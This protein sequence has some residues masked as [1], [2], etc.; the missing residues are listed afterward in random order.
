MNQK[1]IEV[2][3]N[4]K[5]YHLDD[6][7]QTGTSLK[8]LAGIPLGD[9]L[10]LQQRGEDEVIANEAK[11]ALKKRRPPAQPAARRLRFGGG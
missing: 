4:R 1:P 2:F 6:P 10:F 7:I 3:I 11:V 5:K 9:V 8:K